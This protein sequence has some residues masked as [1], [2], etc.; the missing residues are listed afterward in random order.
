MPR[1]SVTPV[2]R[3][4][5]RA[6]S[7]AETPAGALMTD[8]WRNMWLLHGVAVFTAAC[9]PLDAPPAYEE[10]QFLCESGL[11]AALEP[12]RTDWLTNAGCAGVLSMRGEV[13]GL[14]VAVDSRLLS[15]RVENGQQ[16]P[17]PELLRT[18]LK[19]IGRSPY[20]EFVFSQN[21]LGGEVSSEPVDDVL[22]VRLDS[23]SLLDDVGE[24]AVSFGAGLQ[25]EDFKV[26]DGTLRD[27]FRT[28][29]EHRASFHLVFQG[30]AGE[31][32]GCFHALATTVLRDDEPPVEEDDE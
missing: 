7:S 23:D 20:Y 26:E 4:A 2:S 14:P 27:T 5:R 15:A 21:S 19:L 6:S 31:L 3:D 10:E 1:R 32:E 12:C 9:G 18:E 8:T 16:L 30:G 22:Q 28:D 11:E 13:Q 24:V 29:R 25:A 17:Y